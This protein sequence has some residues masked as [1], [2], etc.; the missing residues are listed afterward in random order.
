ME[1]GGGVT[2]GRLGAD[3]LSALSNVAVGDAQEMGALRQQM[4]RQIMR[5]EMHVSSTPPVYPKAYP[6]RNPARH[7][8]EPTL[9][10]NLPEIIK[11]LPGNIQKS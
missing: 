3:M 7:R 9:S 5:E 6:K 4:G 10:N 1:P 8:R 2:P 11:Q